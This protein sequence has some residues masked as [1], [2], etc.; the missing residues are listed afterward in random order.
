[1][2]NSSVDSNAA[3]SFSELKNVYKFCNSLTS[4]PDPR[5]VIDNLCSGET[6]FEVDNVRFITEDTIVS[7]LADE[8]KSDLYC[9]GCF[10]PVFISEN[11]PALDVETIEVLQEEEAFEG[12]GRL[13]VKLCDMEAFAEG[14]ASAD[15]FGHHFNS[16]DFSEVEENLLGVS[17]YIFDN[18]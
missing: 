4:T 11:V 15:G 14:Y 18:Q 7:V 10:K 1:M 17:F 8:L 16:Y 9:L 5:E 2:F 6:D 3:I 13:I 12:I